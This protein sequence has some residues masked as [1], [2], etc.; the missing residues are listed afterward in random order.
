[1]SVSETV[2][3]LL[4]RAVLDPS[5][6]GCALNRLKMHTGSTESFFDMIAAAH[7]FTK[8]QAH[9]VMDGWD[10]ASGSEP[11][12]RYCFRFDSEESEYSDGF[13]LGQ[14][15]WKMTQPKYHEAMNGDR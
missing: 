10:S 7:G 12:F 9:G 2:R 3:E 14:E 6:S 5:T 13:S 15:V 8:Y 11:C 1:M 4:I